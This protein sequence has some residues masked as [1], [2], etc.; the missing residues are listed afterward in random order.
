MGEGLLRTRISSFEDMSNFKT[1]L[2]ERHHYTLLVY[3][4]KT[5]TFKT[6][7]D[8]EK[9]VHAILHDF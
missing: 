8:I 9:K 2:R 5:N 6:K 7:I 4:E 1:C 3:H